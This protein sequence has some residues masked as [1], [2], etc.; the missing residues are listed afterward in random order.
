MSKGIFESIGGGLL[1]AV[2]VATL[3]VPGLQVLAPFAQQLI[4]AG[5]GLLV[6]GIGTLLS[7]QVHGFATT[8][9][10]P[11]EPWEV[12]VGQSRVGGAAV[13]VTQFGDNDRFLDLVIVLAAHPFESVDEVRFD[14]QRLQ[15][16]NNNTSFTP[17]QQ[18]LQIRLTSDI[19]R[20]NNVVTVV[21]E[22]PGSSAD[23]PLLSDG[24]FVVI[25]GVEPT[26]TLMNGRF[27]VT[28]QA[29]TGGTPATGVIF[30]YLSGGPPTSGSGAV[31]VTESGQ[32]TTQWQNYGANVY[33]E[34]IGD[35]GP[36]N[37]LGHAQ[38]LGET[39]LGMTDGT[40]S[41]G[42]L[43]LIQNNGSYPNPWTNFCSLVG[44]TAV[45]LRLQ[46]NVNYFPGGIPQISFIVR[47]KNNILDPRTSLTGY[48]TNSALIIA[49]YLNN[50]IWGFNAAYGTEIDNTALIAAANLCDEQVPITNPFTSPF[51]TE[52]RYT[53]CGRFKLDRSRGE[54][55]E[56]LLTS[57]AG[58]FTY[59]GGLFG[60]YPASWTGVALTL[61]DA[62]IRSNSV[63]PIRWKPTVTIDA[64]YNGIRG[65][66]ISPTSGWQ[67]ADFPYYAQDSEHGYNDGPPIDDFD[68]NLAYDQGQ[69]RW[70]DIQLPFTIS[71]DTAQRL[72]KIELMRNLFMGTGTF[73]FNMAGYQI[74]TLDVLSVSLN[75]FGWSGKYLEVL[76]SRLR[77]EKAKEGSYALLVD[78]DVKETDPSI[79]DFELIE[80]L[81]PQG[82]SVPGVPNAVYVPDAPSNL[83][84]TNGILILTWTAPVDGYVLNGGYIEARYMMISSP[85]GLWISLGNLN[86]S[87]TQLAIPGLEE[88]Q[89]Y[90][91]EL[92][93]VNSA[94]VASQWVSIIAVGPPNFQWQP[95]QIQAP[96]NDALFP[97]EWT[98]DLSQVYLPTSGTDWS[99]AAT[100]TGVFPINR[101]I[102]GCPIPILTA[103]N[104]TIQTTGG[105]ITGGINVYLAIAVND[106]SGNSSAI[107]TILVFAI[108]IGTNTNKLNIGDAAAAMQ[109]EF[110]TNPTDGQMIEI[111][112]KIYT[113]Q[114]TLTNFD[115]NIQ[116]GASTAATLLNLQAGVNLGTGAGTAY[117]AAMTANP[118]CTVTAVSATNVICTANA[119]GV[120]GNLL[121]ASGIANWLNGGNFSGGALFAWPA[122]T[123]LA[124]YT[125]YASMFDDLLAAQATGTLTPT[126]G[127]T[128]YAPT[129]AVLTGPL[130][131]STYAAPNPVQT[132]IRLRGYELIHGGV[133]GAAVFGV[134]STS[135]TAPGC[136]D[137]ASPPV[138]NWA[139]RVIINIGRNN[140]SAPYSALNCTAFN[141][142]TGEFTTSQNPITA[143]WQVGDAM[144]VATLGVSNSG[145][146]LVISDPGLSNAQD[147][148][149]PH[150]GLTV[151]DPT[152]L[153][154]TLLV[155]AGKNRGATAHIVSNTATTLTLDAPVPID[156]TSVWIIFGSTTLY[157][158][159]SVALN[160]YLPTLPVTIA[161]T[162]SNAVGGS[163]LVAGYAVD[164]A[165]NESLID[166]APLRMQFVFGSGMAEVLVS[167][168]ASPPVFSYQML[169]T[170]QVVLVDCTAG[171]VAITLPD[172]SVV[173]NSPRWIKII[174]G[175]NMVMIVGFDG[176]LIEGVASLLLTAIGASWTLIPS[177]T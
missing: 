163:I 149:I 21:L 101:T 52:N 47:G 11:I 29:H 54:I 117:A 155:I 67:S 22:R 80:D 53:C 50:P 119:T 102:T 24:D 1:V 165:G 55:L 93:S 32:V 33:V 13:Y 147:L 38:A 4:S 70:K 167:T 87:I 46:Y 131:R 63:G 130:A 34:T 107:S 7:G 118:S 36:Y 39:F 151:N 98:F 37:R 60:I 133:E 71:P 113:F 105:N 85:P 152:L 142:A 146:T 62:W 139:G 15:I 81:T 99:A 19:T 45:F 172:L 108:P 104:V 48:T 138:D 58:R 114:A 162:V 96:S 144:V 44:F 20:L 150:T 127:G 17:L 143:G 78:V 135:V 65:T 77:L 49:D 91:I 26:N 89:Q 95:N 169:P 5:A 123:G 61:S 148:P 103:N 12:V 171:N 42:S 27:Q 51:T 84:I 116:I 41:Q 83:A 66:Y 128:T 175:S 14:N 2:G 115:G 112:G 129:T 82:Y 120:A 176:Q 170:D 97:S 40:P 79:Y 86:P 57:C 8:E 100:A 23:I 177:A 64:R 59:S 94:G 168:L 75:Y 10:N 16:G 30:T 157:E 174:A 110:S 31:P 137:L 164:D 126:G 166:D 9:R 132:K 72:A 92:R 160:S 140:G 3:I 35:S 158:Q 90:I 28:V 124:S 125:I 73:T 109:G 74:A 88:G 68:V 25:S 56:N 159:D 134:S 154:A 6:T 76:A 136:A 18:T 122:V 141:P 69:R 156:T 111:C 43:P 106:A 161:M 173:R 145:N 121:T 153:G